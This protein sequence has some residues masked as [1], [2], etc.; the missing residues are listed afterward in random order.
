MNLPQ[1]LTPSWKPYWMPPVH[2]SECFG[3]NRF[4]RYCSPAIINRFAVGGVGKLSNG[5]CTDVP[6]CSNTHGSIR[7]I[8]PCSSYSVCHTQSRCRPKGCHMN[9]LQLLE[10]EARRPPSQPFKRGIACAYVFVLSRGKK[11]AFRYLKG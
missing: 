6:I 2:A 9:M 5:R 11:S 8:E 4:L 3:S 10:E 7:R 1:R